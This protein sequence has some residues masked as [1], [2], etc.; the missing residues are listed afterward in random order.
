MEI[1]QECQNFH[2]LIKNL[3]NIRTFIFMFGCAGSS[4][5]CRLFSSCTKWGLLSS[6]CA[7]ASCGSGFTCCTAQAP[8]RAGFSACGC[9]ALEHRLSSCGTLAQLPAACGILLDQGS[10]SCLLHQQADS[11]PLSHQVEVLK[12]N[13]FNKNSYNIWF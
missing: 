1:F 10:N 11:L 4:L 9:Q 2:I 3:F 5:L 8:G 12:K 6:C 13:F 7:Q